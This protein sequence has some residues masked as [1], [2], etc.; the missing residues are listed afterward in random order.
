MRDCGVVPDRNEVFFNQKTGDDILLSVKR[1]F[2]VDENGVVYSVYAV[3]DPV[4]GAK[5]AR[6]SDKGY[7][8]EAWVERLPQLL[9]Q[10]GM[11][12]DQPCSVVRSEEGL[13]EYIM[14]MDVNFT[15]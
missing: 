5:K 1:C 11:L 10:A 12:R 14:S 13:K 9:K 15:H 2:E 4:S 7:S 8:K 6:I 3:T